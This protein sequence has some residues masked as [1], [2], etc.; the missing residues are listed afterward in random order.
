DAGPDA[1][2]LIAGIESAV[3]RG[4]VDEAN[5]LVRIAPDF[6]VPENRAQQILNA[7]ADGRF[8]G[9]GVKSRIEQIESSPFFRAFDYFTNRGEPKRVNPTNGAKIAG[10][11]EGG[12]EIW[13]LPG[14]GY[15][16][17]AASILASPEFGNNQNFGMTSDDFWR[18]ARDTLRE[19]RRLKKPGASFE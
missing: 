12:E 19:Y 8:R 15:D 1:A 17:V 9:A 3:S 16:E 13:N 2:G 5:E 4:A 10:I 11:R 14:S 18:G 7:A 6:G